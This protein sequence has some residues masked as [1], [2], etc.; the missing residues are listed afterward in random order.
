MGNDQSNLKKSGQSKN[1]YYLKYQ[2]YYSILSLS[3]QDSTYHPD[4]V[5]VSEKHEK[6]GMNQVLSG[7]I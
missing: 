3:H 1:Y 2:I 7:L 5:V 4:I 6:S